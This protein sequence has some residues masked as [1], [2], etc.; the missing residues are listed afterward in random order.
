MK[1]KLGIFEKFLSIWVLLCIIT[2][3]AIGKL[4]PTFSQFLS[5]LE[6]AHFILDGKHTLILNSP[7][8]YSSVSLQSSEHHLFQD[9]FSEFLEKS[10]P[11]EQSPL[12][13]SNI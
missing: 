4:F 6:Y 10:L 2:G 1:K 13:S 11:G 12:Y 7:P 5:K 8:Y 9:Y 3:G